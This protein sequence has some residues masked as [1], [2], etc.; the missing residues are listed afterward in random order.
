MGSCPGVADGPGAGPAGGDDGSLVVELLY[1][2]DAD[3]DRAGLLATPAPPTLPESAALRCRR[4]VPAAGIG[5]R[6]AG[7]LRIT[8]GRQA[9]HP[10][11][12][13]ARGAGIRPD[14][15]A[16]AARDASDG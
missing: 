6:A 16:P 11:R 4:Y 15:A 9:R 3:L 12:R 8:S 10:Q 14:Q 7:R 2:G 13:P 5:M 1:A